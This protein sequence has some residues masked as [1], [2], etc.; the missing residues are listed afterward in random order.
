MAF[1]ENREARA[2]ALASAKQT[3]RLII[4]EGFEGG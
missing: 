1:L 2:E 3:K 4:F